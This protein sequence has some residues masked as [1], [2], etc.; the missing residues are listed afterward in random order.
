MCSLFAPDLTISQP[1]IYQLGDNIVSSPISAD[2]IISIQSS[3]VVLDLGQRIISQENLISSVT[4]IS[5]NSNLSNITI[6][7]GT[8]R[9]ISATGIVVSNGC[10]QITIENVVLENCAGRG[11]DFRGTLNSGIQDCLIRGC[12]LLKNCAVSPSDVVI[13]LSLCSRV[14]IE[15]SILNNNG[16]STRSLS[17]IELEECSACECNNISINGNSGSTLIGIELNSTGSCIFNGCTIRKNFAL[18]TTLT[19]I[20]LNNTSRASNSLNVFENCS[21]AENSATTTCVGYL[22]LDRAQQNIL[23]QCSAI[24]NIG[25]SAAIGFQFQRI[26][27]GLITENSL[28]EC[29]ASNNFSTREAAGYYINGSSFCSL[30][31]CIAAFNTATTGICSGLT[32]IGSGGSNWA[33]VDCQFFRNFGN[34]TANSF[35]IRRA[36]GS[37]NLFTRSIAFNNNT[38]QGNQLNGVASVATIASPQTSNLNGVAGPWTNIPVA[39]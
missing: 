8:I 29:L 34:S 2:S 19:G 11:I 31:R 36:V 25:S 20:A 18:T 10:S 32:F 9:N 28:I 39:T 6:K 16:S 14:T 30:I 12:S 24:G 38:T 13:S 1:G 5:I 4:G 17:V 33:I 23:N 22:L 3:N 37:N 21:I 27:S 7:N 35:G 26:S 15:N